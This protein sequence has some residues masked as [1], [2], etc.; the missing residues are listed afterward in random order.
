MCY[1]YCVMKKC[2]FFKSVSMCTALLLT[3]PP[4]SFSQTMVGRVSP[5]P[6]VN[7]LPV[8]PAV[9]HPVLKGIRVDV[10]NPFHLEFIIDPLSDKTITKAEAQTLV[11]YFFAGLTI[12]EDDLWVNLSPYES[13]RIIPDSTATTQLGE[14]LL[15]EDYI[16]KQLA[17]SLTY[18]ETEAGKKYWGEVN[19]ETRSVASLQQAG[20]LDG[21][22]AT[23]GVSRQGA[24]SFQKVWIMPDKAK[25]YENKN[26]AYITQATLKVMM[27]EDYMATQKNNKVDETRS[28]ASL[29]QA[30]SLDGRDV[31]PGVSDSA[32]AFRRHILP[33]ITQEVNTGEHFSRL[34]QIYTALVLGVWFKKKLKDSI[35][36]NYISKSKTKGIDLADKQAKDKTYQ[37]YLNAFK[38]GAYDYVKSE[39]VGARHAS[40]FM[41]KISKRRYF[42]GGI[43]PDPTTAYEADPFFPSSLPSHEFAVPVVVHTVRPVAIRSVEGD[44]ARV[45]DLLV[46]RS[47]LPSS[48]LNNILSISCDADNV[49]MSYMRPGFTSAPPVEL[50]RQELVDELHLNAAQLP[51]LL[52]QLRAEMAAYGK[53]GRYVLTSFDSGMS[54]L[55]NMP[56]FLGKLRAPADT[57]NPAVAPALTN[58]AKDVLEKLAPG[59]VITG[60]TFWPDRIE[61][62]TGP[63]AEVRA[64]TAK[65]SDPY[66]VRWRDLALYGRPVREAQ[67]I[68]RYLFEAEGYQPVTFPWQPEQEIFPF[69]PFPGEP[70]KIFGFNKAL[71][72]LANPTAVISD[73]G[74]PNFVDDMAGKINQI[75]RAVRNSVH[76]YETIVRVEI[77]DDGINLSV[78][79]GGRSKITLSAHELGGDPKALGSVRVT[80]QSELAMATGSVPSFDSKGH[81]VF[82]QNSAKPTAFNEAFTGLQVKHVGPQSSRRSGFFDPWGETGGQPDGGIKITKNS[83]NLQTSGRGDDLAV[84]GDVCTDYVSL[85]PRVL[86]LGGLTRAQLSDAITK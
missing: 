74:Q 24:Q 8:L 14:G 16:L 73:T 30:G 63:L 59:F 11:N 58:L 9:S 64:G 57:R 15:Q 7:L 86:S 33:L 52:Q 27:E 48:M 47:N 84:T 72:S 55:G 75:A 4:Y 31:T 18:P 65:P 23:P 40:P 69:N 32:N 79:G 50:T 21:R 77:G 26:T 20:S 6:A 34:R 25:V 53:D 46:Q 3:L 51:A 1:I 78:T 66:A 54:L 12:P 60:I 82:V 76:V 2:V 61:F 81:T 71:A 43:A 83:I 36:K 56:E 42:S 45:A 44:L 37:A 68:L 28:V 22:D 19:D 70:K 80:L 39:S 13:D 38:Q 67:D 49:S 62:A 10:H 35:Y 17:A 5:A 41:N 29:Q 85:V